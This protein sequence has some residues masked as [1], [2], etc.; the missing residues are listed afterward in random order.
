MVE[1]RES[2]RQKIEEMIQD[3]RPKV[4][5]FDWDPD[6]SRDIY[7][8]SMTGGLRLRIDQ[9]AVDQ[10]ADESGVLQRL[11]MEIESAL[12]DGRGGVSRSRSERDLLSGQFDS[13]VA[14]SSLA[15]YSRSRS[16]FFLLESES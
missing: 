14:S 15:R 7:L 8:L 12:R 2:G 4:S 3:L 9:S 10:A 13:C 6:V 5:G 16:R 1:N 11:K